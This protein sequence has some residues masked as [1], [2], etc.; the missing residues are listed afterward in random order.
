LGAPSRP[1]F[2][3]LFLLEY[4]IKQI[5]IALQ[6]DITTSQEFAR[7]GYKRSHRNFAELAVLFGVVNQYDKDV[8]WKKRAASLA[9]LYHQS[10]QDCRTSTTETLTKAKIGRDISVD[11][12]RGND[13]QIPDSLNGPIDDWGGITDRASLMKRIERTLAKTLSKHLDDKQEFFT[14]KGLFGEFSGCF[15]YID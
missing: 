8:R 9:R 1:G 10:A 11:L 14:N 2:L 6:N 13:V 5:L 4:E 12:V 3:R 7:G 15:W